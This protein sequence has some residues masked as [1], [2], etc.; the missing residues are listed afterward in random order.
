MNKWH[1]VARV[2]GCVDCLTFSANGAGELDSDTVA[3]VAQG[4]ATYGKGAEFYPYSDTDTGEP[5]ESGFTKSPCEVCGLALGHDYEI[6][7]V[8]WHD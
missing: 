5:L 2:R 7:S 4:L 6:G 1:E 3:R 8:M